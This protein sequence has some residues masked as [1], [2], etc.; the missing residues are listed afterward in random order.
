M[1]SNQ[2]IT[3]ADETGRSV[4]YASRFGNPCRSPIP[5][6]KVSQFS[7]ALANGS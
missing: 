1:A 7:Y 5:A 6:A 2:L 3:V 4:A